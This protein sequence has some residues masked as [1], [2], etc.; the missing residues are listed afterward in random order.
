MRKNCF[1]KKNKKLSTPIR[2]VGQAR[3][4]SFIFKLIQVDGGKHDWVKLC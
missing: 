2:K 4:R 3:S 1:S